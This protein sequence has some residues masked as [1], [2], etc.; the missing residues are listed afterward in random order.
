MAPTP[1]SE[2]NSR[3]RRDRQERQRDLLRELREASRPRERSFSRTDDGQPHDGSA[4]RTT[5]AA[6]QRDEQT[7]KKGD[8]K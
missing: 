4:R 5:T 1:P 8:P 6:E 2:D 3:S 7:I